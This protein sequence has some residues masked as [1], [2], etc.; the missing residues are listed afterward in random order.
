MGKINKIKDYYFMCDM[1]GRYKIVKTKT[2]CELNKKITEAVDFS[3]LEMKDFL[4]CSRKFTNEIIDRMITAFIRNC[5]GES[6]FVL[7]RKLN[8]KFVNRQMFTFYKKIFGNIFAQ[9]IGYKI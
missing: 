5:G 2:D 7:Q 8:L 6:Y 1:V 4:L 3:T 9:K